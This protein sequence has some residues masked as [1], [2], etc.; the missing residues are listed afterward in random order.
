MANLPYNRGGVF[1]TTFGAYNCF[2]VDSKTGKSINL[3][4]MTRGGDRWYRLNT[5][6][7]G[8]YDEYDTIQCWIQVEDYKP[9]LILTGSITQQQT[10]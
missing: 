2:L 9:K 5:E 3:G 8:Q 6:L 1:H 4:S 10:A 7:L